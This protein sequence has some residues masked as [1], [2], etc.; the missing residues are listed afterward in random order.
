MLR[1]HK[2]M[3]LP[4]VPWQELQKGTMPRALAES[5]G[6]AA[7]LEFFV[8]HFNSWQLLQNEVFV[9]RIDSCELLSSLSGCPDSFSLRAS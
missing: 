2:L 6:L 5:L 1:S 7:S 3:Q 9:D 4:E 8:N